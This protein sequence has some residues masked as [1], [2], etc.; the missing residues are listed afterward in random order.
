M[1]SLSVVFSIG[2][3]LTLSGCAHSGYQR[4]YVGY[5]TGYSSAYTVQRYYDYPPQSYYRQGSHY[6]TPPLYQHNHPDYDRHHDEHGMRH[7][8]DSRP[9]AAYQGSGNRWSGGMHND[10]N[11]DRPH[12][13]TPPHHWPSAA[14]NQHSPEERRASSQ[15]R[16]ESLGGGFGSWR[17]SERRSAEHPAGENNNRRRH[18]HRGDR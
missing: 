15:A 17:G 18:D 9:H 2:L 4:S 13:N 12:D 11:H 3:V 1:K 5:D 6:Y 7:Q 8:R 14:Q 16:S 10:S